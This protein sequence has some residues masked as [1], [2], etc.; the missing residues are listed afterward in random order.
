MINLQD[1]GGVEEPALVNLV[2]RT[3]MKSDSMKM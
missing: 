3:V 2:V 1:L